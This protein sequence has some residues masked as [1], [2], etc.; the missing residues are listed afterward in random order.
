MKLAAFTL[1][2]AWTPFAASAAHAQEQT[3]SINPQ[4]SQVAFTLGDVLHS[5]HGTFHIQSGSI[6]FDREARSIGGSIVVATGSGDSGNQTRDRK[7][8]KEIL[9]VPQFAVASF[10]PH[11]FQGA[12]APSG[13][14]TIQVSGSFLLHGAPHELMAAVSL[15]LEGGRCTAKSHFVVPY[16][17][18]GLKDPSTFLLHVAKEVDID[19][20]LAGTL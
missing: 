7:M 4:A 11:S 5:V 6:H 20:T 14:S 13:N 10:T 3:C 2:L 12:I 9:D 18:W 8:K 19:L 15:D 16:V 17:Q 1:L